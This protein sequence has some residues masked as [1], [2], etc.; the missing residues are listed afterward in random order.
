MCRTAT[1]GPCSTHH[2]DSHTSAIR[3]DG[4]HARPPPGGASQQRAPRP[5]EGA[6]CSH[7]ST[8]SFVTLECEMTPRHSSGVECIS[9][10]LSDDVQSVPAQREGTLLVGAQPL[11]IPRAVDLGNPLTAL[12]AILSRISNQRF[13]CRRTFLVG[14]RSFARIRFQVS[15]H[16]AVS[17]KHQIAVWMTAARKPAL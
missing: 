4:D 10:P 13:V 12:D 8:A 6:G 15:H 17:T 9:I 1:R 14:L 11:D 7:E 3:L 5:C 2:N 16:A